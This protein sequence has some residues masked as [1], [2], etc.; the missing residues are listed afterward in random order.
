[1]LVVAGLA[2][3]AWWVT[4]PLRDAEDTAAASEPGALLTVPE[5]EQPVERAA[6]VLLPS[7]VHLEVGNG[8]MGSGFVFDSGAVLTAAHVIGQADEVT[9]RLADGTEVAGEVV[10]ANRSEDIAVIEVDPA[11]PGL[12]VADLRTDEPARVGEATVAVGSPFGFNQTVTSGIVS[13]LDRTLEMPGLTLSGLIQ[14]D[15]PINPGNSG[16]PLS[17]QEGSVIGVNTAIASSSGGSD[18]VGFA[19]PIVEAVEVATDL[20]NGIGNDPADDP[21]GFGLDQLLPDLPDLGQELDEM[22]PGLGELFDW[23]LSEEGLFGSSSPDAPSAP[24]PSTST[25]LP[26]SPSLEPVPEGGLLGIDAL[27][28]DY[29]LE[30]SV[31]TVVGPATDPVVVHEIT[32]EGPDGLFTVRAEQ[33]SEAQEGYE[34]LEPSGDPIQVRGGDGI[35]LEDRSGTRVVWL[36]DSDLVVEI[37]AP[38]D[39]P[40]SALTDL[41]KRLQVRA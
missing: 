24:T 33:S 40:V 38:R 19:I 26:S 27:D 10:G 6:R 5:N 15:A 28:E 25:T 3:G 31:L 12:V 23:L 36:E 8:A 14:T 34:R 2:A 37:Q 29:R 9:V 13:G 35:A 41:A 39:T 17:D 18:G 1:V 30:S 22:L 32:I 11:T 20:R 4:E 7:V 16:G 21:G